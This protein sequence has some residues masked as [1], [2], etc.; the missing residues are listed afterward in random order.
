MPTLLINDERAARGARDQPLRRGGAQSWASWRRL[1]TLA[2]FVE[3]A[4]VLELVF[5]DLDVD[6]RHACLQ[7][8]LHRGYRLVVDQRADFFEEEA[9]Q[10]ASGDVADLLF[11]VLEEIAFYGS[12]GFLACVFGYLDGH[13]HPVFSEASSL[14]KMCAA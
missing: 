8:L 5:V 10:R 14:S 1:P 2:L 9:Q 6:L 4:P 12:D 7:A 11:H 13:G 3:L